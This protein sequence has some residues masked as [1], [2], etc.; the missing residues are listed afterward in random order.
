MLMIFVSNSGFILSLNSRAGP[1]RGGRERLSLK[2]GR[3][4]GFAGI[5]DPEREALS[6]GAFVG[7]TGGTVFG[8]VI[9]FSICIKM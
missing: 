2:S 3:A 7:A 1:R 5:A 8:V 4:L 6:T 9:V